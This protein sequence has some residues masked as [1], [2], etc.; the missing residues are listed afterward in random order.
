[1]SRVFPETAIVACPVETLGLGEKTG[2]RLEEQSKK[3][4]VVA[5]LTC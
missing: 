3:G 4:F 2:A 1:L 5:G